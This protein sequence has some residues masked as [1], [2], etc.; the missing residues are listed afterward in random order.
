MPNEQRRHVLQAALSDWAVAEVRGEQARVVSAPLLDQLA[1]LLSNLKEPW[2]LGWACDAQRPYLVRARLQ[3][4]SESRE[5]LAEA[6]DL[7]EARR[8]ALADALQFFGVTL[9][10]HWV[11]YDPEDGPNTTELVITEALPATTLPVADTTATT[12]PQM[13]KA[14]DHIDRLVET[15]RDAGLGKKAAVVVARHGGYGNSVE[16][17]RAIYKELQSLQKEI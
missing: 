15:L 11:D 5:G 4:G 7:E 16:E 10:E 6:P 9:Q 14:R 2:S 13:E 17:S 3:V 8:L 12:D 1:P